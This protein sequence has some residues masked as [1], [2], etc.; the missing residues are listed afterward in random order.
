ML[1]K[2]TMHT[3]KQMNIKA[4]DLPLF[5]TTKPTAPMIITITKLTMS[6]APISNPTTTVEA[7]PTSTGA[8]EELGFWDAVE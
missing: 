5:L 6:M 1:R 8:V 3:S 4:K 2:A 7:P